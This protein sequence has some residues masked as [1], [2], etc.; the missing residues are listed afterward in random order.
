M[1]RFTFVLAAMVI[2]AGCGGL[3]GGS[4]NEP[5]VPQN[6]AP[7]KSKIEIAEADKSVIFTQDAGERS[8][9]FFTSENWTASL[10]NNR[11][12]EW[13]S[14]SPT[15]G[16]AGFSSMKITV[17]ANNTADNRSASIQ[18]KSGTATVTIVVTQKQQNALTVAQ[19]RFDVGAEGGEITVAVAANISVEYSI[20]SGATSWIHPSQGTK[21]RAMTTSQF[22]FTIDPNTTNEKREDAIIIYGE[23]LSETIM[24]YQAAGNSGGE[25]TEQPET[26]T[27]IVSTSNVMLTS[28]A[29]SFSVEV[30]YNIDVTYEISDSWLSHADTR[31]MSTN[32][33]IF[34]VAE[35]ENTY[36]RTATIIF[37][38]VETGLSQT[39]TVTQQGASPM[40]V[41]SDHSV[42]L[43]TAAQSF[44]IKV[45]HNT[46]ISCTISPVY[47]ISLID[48]RAMQTNSFMFA[49]VE[50]ED[51]EPRTATITFTDEMNG[52]SETVEVT[53]AEAFPSIIVSQKELKLS[54]YEQWLT[55]EVVHNV[56]IEWSISEDATWLTCPETRGKRIDWISFFAEEN[57]DTEP[58]TATITFTDVNSGI[59]DKVTVS[60]SGG[61]PVMVV[62]PQEFEVSAEGGTCKVEVHTNVDYIVNIPDEAASWISVVGTRAMRDETITFQISPNDGLERSAVVEVRAED[63]FMWQPIVF[64]Q[65]ENTDEHCIEL[66]YNI[67]TLADPTYLYGNMYNSV[68]FDGPNFRIT[69]VVYDGKEYAENYLRNYYWFDRL[70]DVVI[71]VYYTG[72]MTS[73]NQFGDGFGNIRL[74]SID[75]PK[76]VDTFAKRI[77][78]NCSELKSIDIPDA[79][80]TLPDYAFSGCGFEH[81]KL[82]KTL[83]KLGELV[84][85]N[86]KSLQEI[87]I[88]EGIT[89]IPFAIFNGCTSLSKVN[90]PQSVTIIDGGAF[91]GCTSLK[92]IE[93]PDNLTTLKGFDYSGIESIRF[94][95]NIVTIG[96][97]SYCQSLKEVEFDPDIQLKTI[98]QECFTNSQFET[99]TIPKSVESIDLLAFASCDRL[100]SVFFAEGSKIRT[101]N[102]EV[103]ANCTRLSRIELPDQ[104]ENLGEFVFQNTPALTSITI[105]AS[106]RII[107]KN[108]FSKSGLKSIDIPDMVRKIADKAFYDCEALEEVTLGGNIHSIG[109]MAFGFCPNMKKFSSRTADYEVTDD[110]RCLV[111]PD[112][113]INAFASIGAPDHYKIPQATKNYTITGIGEGS[114]E[115]TS[116]ST[117]TL[118][119]TINSIK[120]LAFIS[121]RYAEKVFDGKVHTIYFTSTTPPE[122]GWSTD[123]GMGGMMIGRTHNG[124]PE[125]CTIFVP[126][127][128]LN[129]YK[130]WENHREWGSLQQTII[131]YEP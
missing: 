81:I 127:S 125:P 59:S 103:F 62:S 113:I 23:G 48:T 114:F 110:G 2:F 128:S 27:I 126:I 84:F 107:E 120:Q 3:N 36:P 96:G 29:Q 61:E 91:G 32:T 115:C 31:A 72:I 8:I 66:V 57:E 112:G 58:R 1:K 88:P 26:P 118:P 10:I 117:V 129:L 19:S 80:T 119:E 42:E 9:S 73:I 60:Q 52:L 11:A 37:T 50:N 90:L 101:I 104:L 121:S 78:Q 39:V 82:P 79:V 69:R 13:C 93:L 46:G 94:G 76:T 41:V 74:K 70:G 35:N 64:M 105:P 24:V 87:D 28:A 92:S 25:E 85:E 131:G 75:I 15:S 34:N 95:R 122:L 40:L 22:A 14:V 17:A 12:D 102:S 63:G 100:E 7:V 109:V 71:Q 98:P 99:I 124:L 116:I 123:V 55:V 67:N 21:T 38:N 108:V 47:W 111:G 45:T 68:M 43:S 83:T 86:C 49:V 30:S 77:F 53:Q 89:K 5:D 51:T 44:E 54:H 16:N 65:S 6:P 33:F 56:D 20:A 106:M 18:L 130:E 4:D 97:F